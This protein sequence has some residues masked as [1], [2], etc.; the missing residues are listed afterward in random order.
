MTNHRK[1]S[2]TNLIVGIALIL[3]GIGG[4]ASLTI[5][6]IVGANLFWAICFILV[7][8]LMGGYETGKYAEMRHGQRRS[9]K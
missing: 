6:N 7:L 3:L 9:T 4:M 1:A 2:S 5:S 8:V